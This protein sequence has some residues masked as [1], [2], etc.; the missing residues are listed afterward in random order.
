VGVYSVAANGDLTNVFNVQDSGVLELDNPV[1]MSIAVIGGTTYLFVAGADDD[2]LSVFS[3]AANGALTN[4]ANVT[5]NAEHELDRAIGVTTVAV[6]GQILV[7][8]ASN[9]DDGVST[10][11]FDDGINDEP[12]LTATG[13][14]PTFTEGGG[15]ADL[16][17]RR[18]PRPLNRARP[19][20]R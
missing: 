3:V 6:D 16:T 11:V 14:D 7:I 18:P 20:R 12:T 5:D 17:A 1:A 13:N 19:S 2:G 9:T 15:A 8:A 10:F 4:V